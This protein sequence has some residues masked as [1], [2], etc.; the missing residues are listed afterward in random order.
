MKN[1][2][3][4]QALLDEDRMCVLEIMKRHLRLCRAKKEYEVVAF[5]GLIQGKFMKQQQRGM[6]YVSSF[7]FTKAK[8]LYYFR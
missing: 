4:S 8:L 7:L 2:G 6:S 1:P 3:F 5:G